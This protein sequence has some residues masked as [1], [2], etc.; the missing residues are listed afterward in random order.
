MRELPSLVKRNCKLFFRDK[1]MFFTSLITPMIL[2]ILYTTFLANL[3]RD[4]FS[5]IL[6]AGVTVS[7]SLLDGAVA[8]QLLSS[9]LAVSSVTV[10]FCSNMLM[11]QDRVTGARRDLTMAPVRT[12][13]LALGYYLSTVITTLIVCYFAVL[14]GLLYIGISGWYLSFADV[15]L[16]LLDVFLL[17]M[18]GTAI[19][20]IINF[21]LTSQGQISAVGTIVSAGYGFICGAYLPISEFSPVLRD[22]VMFSPGTY[23]TALLRNHTMRGVLSEMQKSGIPSELTDVIRRLVDYKLS[24]FGHDVKSYVMY[25]A[26]V[27]ST[28][29]LV[30]VYLAMNLVRER[31]ARAAR[32]RSARLSELNSQQN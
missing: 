26:L 24:F 13:T 30:G 12:S 16:I 25:L 3:Y 4:N 32:E 14:L 8:G 11:V 22:A 18:F 23:G 21:F 28:L 10:S 31:S 17:V 5:S 29:A 19:S 9:L 6:S 27:G 20:S 15:V 7:D 1:G 2:L